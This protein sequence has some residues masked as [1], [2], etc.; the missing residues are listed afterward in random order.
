MDQWSVMLYKVWKQCSHKVLTHTGQIDGE[1]EG[2]ER[3]HR[4]ILNQYSHRRHLT[5]IY[6]PRVDIQNNGLI[7]LDVYH[8]LI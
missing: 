4:Q 8:Q 5:G 3:Q 7:K 1:G 2:K 6:S